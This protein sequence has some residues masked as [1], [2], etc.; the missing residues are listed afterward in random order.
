MKIEKELV[1]ISKDLVKLSRRIRKLSSSI[2]KE[3]RIVQKAGMLKKAALRRGKKSGKQTVL[4]MIQEYQ[5]G[6]DA[7]TLKKNT[8]FNDKKIRNILF[9]ALKDGKIERVRRGV[10]KSSK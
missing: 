9:K 5:T 4:D 3:I 7:R 1:K 6:I 8:G 2:T 10:Y